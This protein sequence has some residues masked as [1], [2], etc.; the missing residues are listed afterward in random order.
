MPG[1][2]YSRALD[3]ADFTWTR[4]RLVEWLA[5]PE[6]LVPGQRM[7]VSVEDESAQRDIVDYLESVSK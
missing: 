1:F 3:G 6:A 4:E 2:R 5:D 7:N